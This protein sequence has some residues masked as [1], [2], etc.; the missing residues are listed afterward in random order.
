MKRFPTLV[1]CTFAVL[2]LAAA[3]G[4]SGDPNVEGAKLDLRN[5]DYDRALENVNT[6]L[7]TNPDNAEALELKGRILMA[8]AGEVNDPDQHAQIIRD[9]VQAFNRAAQVDPEMASVIEFNLRNAYLQ[10]FERGVQAYTRGSNDPAEFGTAAN[11][12]ANAALIQPDSA[13][14][15]INQAYSLVAAERQPEAITALE[16]AIDKGD[17]QPDTYIYLASLYSQNERNEDAVT[18]LERA[19]EANPD[20]SDVQAQLLQAYVL[21]GQMDRAMDFYRQAVEREPGNAVYRYNYGSLLLQAEQYDEAVEQL[22]EAVALDAENSNAQYNLGAAYINQ[23]VSVNERIREMDDRLREERGT[24]SREQIQARETE[25]DGLVQQRTQ[26]FEVAIPALERARE[27]ATLSGESA[28][29]PCRALFQAY[30]NTRQTEK[31]QAV[32]ACAGYSEEN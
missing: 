25:I 11:I 7:A 20:N 15:Y 10:E 17:T 13:G 24:L 32:A 23:A 14:A 1:A 28:T 31:A 27:L 16:T 26:L 2:L 5:Q 30:T 4:C 6:A 12:F 22:R 9:M 21:A 19:R 29:G 18:I 8:Q 3:N